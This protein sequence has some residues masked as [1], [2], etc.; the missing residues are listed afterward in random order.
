MTQHYVSI[1]AL[2]SN[3]EFKSVRS[4][5]LYAHL[6]MLCVSEFRIIYPKK[7]GMPDPLELSSSTPFLAFFGWSLKTNKTLRNS[8]PR[9]YLRLRF[10]KKAEKIH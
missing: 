6:L 2:I 4:L 5:R 8:A 7:W 9:K 1:A 3:R 10:K